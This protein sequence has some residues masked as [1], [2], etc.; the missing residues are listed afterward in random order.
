MYLK[1][2]FLLTTFVYFSTSQA[3][4]VTNLSS[5]LV[6]LLCVVAVAGTW[7]GGNIHCPA[8]DKIFVNVSQQTS[9]LNVIQQFDQPQ[10]S[11]ISV[12]TGCVFNP[13]CP[14]M[15]WKS[16]ILPSGWS[17]HSV[18]IILLLCY[19]DRLHLSSQDE[20]QKRSCRSWWCGSVSPCHTHSLPTAWCP[21]CKGDGQWWCL[22]FCKCTL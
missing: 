15:S 5:E 22:S 14:Q 21:W 10:N 18:A 6:W 13:R 2:L 19:I 8:S 3:T 16:A 11:N 1:C 4:W 12:S 9:K 20:V 17:T 7:K